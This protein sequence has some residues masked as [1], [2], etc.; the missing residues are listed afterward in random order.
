MESKFFIFVTRAPSKS[1]VRRW[2]FNIYFPKHKFSFEVPASSEGVRIDL[3]NK[4]QII[5]EVSKECAENALTQ[6]LHKW[7]GLL[8]EE[9]KRALYLV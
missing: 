2:V 8:N 9:E 1:S 5:R 4:D 7:R 6:L 3:F